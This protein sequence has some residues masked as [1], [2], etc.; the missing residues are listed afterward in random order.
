MSTWLTY[1][2]L[3]H[4][5]KVY[6]PVLSTRHHL[7][8]QLVSAGLVLMQLALPKLRSSSGLKAFNSS[9]ESVEYDL[10]AWRRRANMS[11]KDTAIL[12]AD[13]S[14]GWEL[15]EALLRPRQIEVDEE[16][17]AVKFVNTNHEAVRLSVSLALTHNF[18]KQVGNTD[19]S[20]S[21]GLH[22]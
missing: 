21:E 22:H 14:A 5:L 18:M 3:F 4:T 13:D 20:S 17:G 15:A 8:K 19:L 1:G 2:S 10:M 9:L 16:T 7:S 11:P 12:D 6:L